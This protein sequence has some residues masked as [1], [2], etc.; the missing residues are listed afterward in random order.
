MK[1]RE[2][3]GTERLI[4][5]LRLMCLL[6]ILLLVG[7][8]GVYHLSIYQVSGLFKAGAA[9]MAYNV[10]NDFSVEE[11]IAELPENMRDVIENSE[12]SFIQLE[13]REKLFKNYRKDLNYHASKS[14]GHANGLTVID[15]KVVYLS[16]NDAFAHYA[17]PHE[18][19]HVLDYYYDW[20]SSTEEFQKIYLEEAKGYADSNYHQNIGHATSSKE[21]F[22]ASVCC[23]IVFGNEKNMES[24]PKAVAYVKQFV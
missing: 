4:W 14:Y 13:K 15:E 5:G 2:L 18:V 19:G 6:C 10:V 7:I 16:A 8:I 20:A 9:E 1:L 12:F 17:F 21:E 24:A 22:F 11:E 3:S 23:D